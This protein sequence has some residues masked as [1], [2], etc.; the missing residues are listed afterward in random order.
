MAMIDLAEAARAIKTKNRVAFHHLH[1]SLNSALRAQFSALGA[2]MVCNAIVAVAKL[3]RLVY[4]HPKSP[5]SPAYK[6]GAAL[7]LLRF[8]DN[9]LVFLNRHTLSIKPGQLSLFTLHGR[10]RFDLTLS[11]VKLVIFQKAKLREIVLNERA[12]KV[13]KLRFYLDSVDQT[14]LSDG[15]VPA[16]PSLESAMPCGLIPEYVSVEVPP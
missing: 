1:H 9:C 15:D 8:F 11:P 7:P 2:Q 13:F 14:V 3:V 16:L 12:D 5:F 10:M 6:S 4:Q